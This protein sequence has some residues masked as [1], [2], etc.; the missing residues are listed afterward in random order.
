MRWRRRMHGRP[1]RRYVS[2][3]AGEHIMKLVRDAFPRRYDA[4]RVATS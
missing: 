4:G 1:P 2:V 3:E